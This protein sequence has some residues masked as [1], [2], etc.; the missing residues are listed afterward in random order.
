MKLLT[1][2]LAVVALATAGPREKRQAN[3]ECLWFEDCFDVAQE[4][5]QPNVEEPR[6][7]RDAQSQGQ[8]LP[9]LDTYD[10]C[11]FGIG[12]CVPYYLC[13][14]GDIITDGAGLIDIR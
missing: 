6:T 2:L 3:E 4:P 12:S 9:P 10:K 11:N 13:H 1:L 5:T 14:D 7:P 8:T